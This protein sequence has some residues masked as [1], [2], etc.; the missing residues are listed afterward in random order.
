M[1]KQILTKI[2]DPAL[3]RLAAHRIPVTD[4]ARVMLYWKKMTTTVANGIARAFSGK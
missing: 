1:S 4:A 2:I 3:G